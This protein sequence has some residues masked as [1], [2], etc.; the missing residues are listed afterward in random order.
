M[1][2]WIQDCLRW[3]IGLGFRGLGLVLQI[4]HRFKIRTFSWNQRRLRQQYAIGAEVPILSYGQELEEL[5]QSAASQA[6]QKGYHKRTETRTRGGSIPQIKR[7]V[8][9]K[10]KMAPYTAKI[11]T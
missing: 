1:R 8:P 2:G 5:I 11:P 9:T 3:I 4:V 10:G 6:G 7:D